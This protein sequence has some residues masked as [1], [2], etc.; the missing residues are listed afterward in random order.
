M[1]KAICQL[2]I[3]LIQVALGSG[4]YLGMGASNRLTVTV[5]VHRRRTSAL[6]EDFIILPASWKCPVPSVLQYVSSPIRASECIARMLPGEAKH[7]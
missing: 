3:T 6:D 7:R 2:P 1:V 5:S 4:H